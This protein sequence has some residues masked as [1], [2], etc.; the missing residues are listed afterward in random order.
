MRSRAPSC[1]RFGLLGAAFA[2]TVSRI[3]A[4]SSVGGGP[5]RQFPNES[6]VFGA[7]PNLTML[8][9]RFR[10][11]SNVHCLRQTRPVSSCSF[12]STLYRPSPTRNPPPTSASWFVFGTSGRTY[13]L[14]K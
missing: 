11:A 7:M 5:A 6:A 3:G 10:P 1:I 4:A 2:S 14:R 12:Q 8:S 9:D 13:R